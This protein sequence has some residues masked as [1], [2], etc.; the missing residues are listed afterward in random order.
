[1]STGLIIT[2]IIGIGILVAVFGFSIK[3]HN[4]L[5]EEGKIAKRRTDF[6]NYS[7]EFTSKI[8]SKDAVTA[9]VRQ[10]DYKS[11]RANMEGNSAQQKFRFTGSGYSAVLK[12]ITF[13][14]MSGVAIYEFGFTQFQ[15][16]GSIPKNAL[17]MNKLLTQIEQM[18]FSLDPN[19]GV[20]SHKV[21][22]KT[23]HSFF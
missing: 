9:A 16:N 21:D 18:F 19:T 23:R 7:S 4:K 3:A 5:I 14:E 22:F 20:K 11:I 1:M 12:L 10:L 17:S 6:A 13:D 8:G 2:L 15:T